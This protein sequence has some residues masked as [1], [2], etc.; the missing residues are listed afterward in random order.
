MQKV[1][2]NNNLVLNLPSLRVSHNI[3]VADLLFEIS[4]FMFTGYSIISFDQ[5]ELIEK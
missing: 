4:L 5:K 2:S 3:D 1:A